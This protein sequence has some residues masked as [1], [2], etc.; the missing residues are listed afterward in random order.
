M[1]QHIKNF[2]KH[3]NLAPDE[4]FGCQVC[5]GT[6]VDIHHIVFRSANGSDDV[7]NLIGLC[8]SC[9]SRSH[10]LATPYLEKEELQ[11]IVDKLC[12]LCYSN[13]RIT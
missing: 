1:K 13:N 11:E 9:H 7:S 6:A 3:Y 10:K 5:G 2:Y 4:W 12:K 8:R